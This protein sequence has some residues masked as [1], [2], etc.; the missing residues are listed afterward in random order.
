VAAQ[1]AQ[2]ERVKQKKLLA[3]LNQKQLPASL[4]QKQQRLLLPRN[5]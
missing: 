3:L 1:G 5:A 2:Q 4:L